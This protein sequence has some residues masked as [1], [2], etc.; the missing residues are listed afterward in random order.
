M[1]GVLLDVT[2]LTRDI[3]NVTRVQISGDD[4]SNKWKNLGKPW[5]S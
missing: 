5:I 4:K 3:E 2:K 1:S